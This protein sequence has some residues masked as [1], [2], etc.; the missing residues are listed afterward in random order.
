M[1][2]EEI[3]K[4]NKTVK[5]RTDF[6][7]K[8]VNITDSILNEIKMDGGCKDYFYSDNFVLINGEC[9]T[10]MNKLIEHGVCVDHIITDIPYGTVQGLEIE[11]WKNKGNI[12]EWDSPI[13]IMEMLDACFNISKSNSN[14]ILFSQE[15]MTFKLYYYAS[16]FQKYSIS[17]KMIWVKNNHANG[18]SAK[19]TPLNYYE[20]MLLFRKSLDETNSI[21]IREYFKKL[22]EYINQDRKTIMSEINQ[23]LDHC[24]RYTHRTFY[25]PIERN[26]DALIEHYNIDKMDG[27]IPYSILK[28][29]WD[30]ENKTIFNIPKGQAIVKNVFEVKKDTKNIHPTQKPVALLEQLIELF[31][32]SNETIL[33][34]TSGSGSTG[35]ACNKYNRKFIGIEM[36]ESFYNASLDWYRY[37]QGLNK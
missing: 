21:E 18:F 1:L 7:K 33:D 36:D 25:L 35:I 6:S 23:G 37:E 3:K 4:H 17:N 32:N 34:F 15:P 27:F 24:F 29:Q 22:L 2:E 16:I 12:P 14:M 19:T 8:R 30:S 13:D 5:A 10:V 31:S 11:G 28:K 20:E 9:I 26:Y